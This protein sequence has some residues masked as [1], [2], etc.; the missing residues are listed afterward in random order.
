MTTR[1]DV[2]RYSDVSRLHGPLMVVQG[3]KDVGWDEFATIQ[4]TGGPD[5]HGLV[6]DVDGDLAVV[7][8][9]EGTQGMSTAST[10]VS[11]DGHP[12]E[13]SVG[14]SWLGRVCDGRGSR[15]TAVHR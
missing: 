3:V 12:L 7:E 14:T 2:V 8:V 6:L 11:F 9:L 15:V 4:I 13:I 10:S 1:W 5:R